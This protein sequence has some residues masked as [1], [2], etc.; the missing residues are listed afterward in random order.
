MRLHKYTGYFS[1]MTYDEMLSLN[2]EKLIAANITLG[3]RK[4]II[5]HLEKL[6]ERPN[7][8]KQLCSVRYE[9][10]KYKNY[11]FMK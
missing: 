7:R 10:L 4:K 1:H 3:A 8:L 9:W 2:D 5:S 6:R 11:I